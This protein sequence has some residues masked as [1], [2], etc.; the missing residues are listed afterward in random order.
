V[1]SP[2]ARAVAGTNAAGA[3]LDAAV[4]SLDGITTGRARILL[5]T[6]CTI[7][8]ALSCNAATRCSADDTE[9]LETEP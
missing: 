5:F 9:N 6:S 8:F 3:S 2:S 4:P 7:A 1:A